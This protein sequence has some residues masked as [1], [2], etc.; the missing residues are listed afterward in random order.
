MRGTLLL[1]KQTYG[2]SGRVSS[3]RR[4]KKK[5]ETKTFSSE[6]DRLQWLQ[7]G[8]L[9]GW[10]PGILSN[11]N[12]K[13]L[14]RPI[15]TQEATE[16]VKE[17]LR[18][19][20]KYFLFLVFFK[21]KFCGGQPYSRLT[22]SKTSKTSLCLHGKREQLSPLTQCITV[23]ESL[24]AGIAWFTNM[25]RDDIFTGHT[26]TFQTSQAR[27]KSWREQKRANRSMEV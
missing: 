13:N 22:H 21:K 6:P 25:W 16:K 8:Y 18:K 26:L 7:V 9:G 20:P 27:Q 17:V 5:F 14:A 2:G 15:K 23:N 1:R 24:C 3:H 19:W 4:L 11:Y 12:E 10:F